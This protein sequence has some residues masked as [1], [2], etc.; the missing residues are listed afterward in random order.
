[1]DVRARRGKTSEA[2]AGAVG[3]AIPHESSE[4]HVSGEAL[5][6][7]DIVEPKGLLHIAVGMSAKAHA[8]INSIDLSAV[9]EAPGVVAVMTADDIPGENN[10]GPVIADDPVF[11]PG[12]V[13]FVGQAVFAVAAE[14]VDQARKAARLGVIEYE[15]LEPILD[16]RSA[17]AAGSFVLPS[18][19]IERGDS[20]GA[21]AAAPHR[22]KGSLSV[23]GQ[24]QFYL[25]GQIAMA[26]PPSTRAKCSI[27]SP[28]QSARNRRTSWSSAAAWAALSVARRVN[29]HLLPASQPWWPRKLADRASFAWTGMTT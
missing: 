29:R 20:A 9:L 2:I 18:E 14:T 19:T 7:D 8:R 5:Y 10:C 4:L 23:G 26:L 17:L 13:Q 15:E 21:I 11:A 27:S 24:D 6:T 3:E 12:L 22:L 16:P 1:M 25:E 28:L